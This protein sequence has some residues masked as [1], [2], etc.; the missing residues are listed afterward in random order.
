[1][2]QVDGQRETVDK[3]GVW[4]EEDFG[5]RSDKVKG[6]IRV[7]AKAGIKLNVKNLEKV[8]IPPPGMQGGEGKLI[9]DLM[10]LSDGQLLGDERG[11]DVTRS[12][13]RIG[14][15][16]CNDSTSMCPAIEKCGGK[17]I[18]VKLLQRIDGIE[19]ITEEKE[20]DPRE[21]L[22]RGLLEGGELGFRL[23]WIGE[24]GGKDVEEAQ[25]I[26]E[27]LFPEFFG[28]GNEGDIED[29]IVEEVKMWVKRVV[30]AMKKTGGEE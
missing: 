6:R 1:M 23:I 19:G 27:E 16:K 25:G 18:R 5:D 8:G 24:R 21:V 30:G 11:V 15:G 26:A 29:G 3:E 2:I 28:Q 12:I 7:M 20:A 4:R 9:E 10:S 22:G 17:G 13:T 14:I